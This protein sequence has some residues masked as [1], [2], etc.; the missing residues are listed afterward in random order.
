M[1]FARG[2]RKSAAYALIAG[3]FFTPALLV[4]HGIAII[5]AL[6]GVFVPFPAGNWD[7]RL[8]FEA[9]RMIAI[10]I[11]LI[12]GVHASAAGVFGSKW[13][14]GQLASGSV[15]TEVRWLLIM[16]AVLVCAVSAALAF[17]VHWRIH[18]ASIGPFSIAVATG[19]P[20]LTDVATHFQC[21]NESGP[22]YT[23]RKKLQSDGTAT[24]PAQYVGLARGPLRCQLFV[25][26]PE[27]VRSYQV[28]YTI[29]PKPRQPVTLQARVPRWSKEVMLKDSV[30]SS[31]ESKFY[32]DT[33][34]LIVGW[35]PYMC[36]SDLERAKRLYIPLLVQRRRDVLAGQPSRVSSDEDYARLLARS[37]DSICETSASLPPGPP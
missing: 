36:R 11:V 21:S 8:M 37:W 5:P 31:P 34:E 15:R 12:F 24:F 7:M 29:E 1:V 3:V 27:L 13:P 23:G 17:R 33:N 32:W 20:A 35:L 10:A 4:G 30:G 22:V 16:I 28:D 19:S 25:K 14:Q 2:W 18:K 9:L 6:V 26:H